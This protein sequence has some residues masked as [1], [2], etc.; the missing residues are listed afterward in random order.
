MCGIVYKSN[1]YTNT[2]EKKFIDAVNTLSDRG[3]DDYGYLFI[4]NHSF[5]HRRLE[6][7]D[8]ENSK[9]PMS[10]MNHHLV[11]NGEIY[12]VDELKELLNE[13]LE[14]ES[15]TLLLLKLLMKYG[16]SILNK[17]N[18]IFSFVYTNKDDVLIVRD[19]FGIKPLYYTYINND[20]FVASEIKAILSYTNNRVIDSDGLKELI[21][22]GPSHS[23]GKTIYKGIYELKPGHLIK[24][25]KE[26]KEIKEYYKL[27]VYKYEESYEDTVLK[28][29][30]LIDKVIKRQM[31]ADVDVCCFLS[32]GLDS[33]IVSKMVSDNQDCLDTYSIIYKDSS[34]KENEFEK[35]LDSEFTNIVSSYIYSHQNDVYITDDELINHLHKTV[36]IKDG[37]NMTDIDSSLYHICD[38]ISDKHKL[39]MSGECADEL[40]GGYPWYKNDFNTFPWMKDLSL[41]DSLLNDKY[42]KKLKIKEYVKEEYDKAILEAPVLDNNDNHRIL[43]YLNIKYFM[44]SLLDRKDR[45][46]S[47]VGLEVR[48]PFCD[49]E[50]VEFLYNVPYEYKC[51]DGIE[52]KL[53]RDAYKNDLPLEIIERKKSPYP[54]SNSNKYDEMIKN[55]LIKVL[56]DKDSILYEIFDIDKLYELINS[57]EEISPWYGQL[58]RK[59]ALLT[60]LYQIDY[61]FKEYEMRLEE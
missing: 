3:P 50:L 38:V 32:G 11:Y 22:M 41:K 58:M 36:K 47:S 33:S 5:G 60:Y 45:I 37:P 21:G 48:V 49:R 16:E 43:T 57:E 13:E 19:M 23:L 39:A 6:I 4:K 56:E 14:Y 31:V 10:I 27:P 53:L 35:S 1:F 15:D 51:K 7:R 59:T 24:I 44:L 8:I 52:K 9:Q 20:I 54:K 28:V 34:F 2:D 55:L 25:N 18:G 29:K 17:I 42:R 30:T 61:W 46:S 26:K 12:N 40:F